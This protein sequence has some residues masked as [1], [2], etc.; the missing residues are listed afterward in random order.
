VLDLVPR[1]AVKVNDVAVGRVESIGLGGDDGWT[2]Q[3]V[4][5]VNGDVE[6]PADAVANVRQSSLLGEK[7][8]ELAVPDAAR[9]PFERL[10]DG[11]VIPVERT[12][13]HTEVEEAFGAMSMLA[14]AS[15]RPSARSCPRR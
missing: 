6:L 10:S 14:S 1:A 7:F 4:L 13:R 2:A 5:A 8:V 3:A 12:N 15:C 11:A 9:R